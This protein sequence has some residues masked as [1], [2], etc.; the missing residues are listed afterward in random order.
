MCRIASVRNLQKFVNSVAPADPHREAPVV[1]VVEFH[2]VE[3]VQ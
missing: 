2:G 3:G 1:L